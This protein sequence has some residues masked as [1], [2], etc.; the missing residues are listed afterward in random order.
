MKAPVIAAWMN[1]VKAALDTYNF[2]P[3]LIFNFDETMLDASEHKV[4]VL[5]HSGDEKPFTE[6]ET[7]LKYM[8]LGLCISA[9]GFYVCPLLILPLK[10]LSGVVPQVERFFSFSG[11]ANGFINNK[12][13]HDWVKKVLISHINNICA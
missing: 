7:K 6:N 5:V 10:Y 12:I 13:W 2:P 1:K 9:S 3:E 4:K 11:Q 8:S